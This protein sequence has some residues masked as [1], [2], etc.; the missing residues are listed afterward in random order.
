M[1]SVGLI[2]I[3]ERAN[4]TRRKLQEVLEERMLLDRYSNSRQHC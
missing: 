1:L 4:L 3:C 2:V